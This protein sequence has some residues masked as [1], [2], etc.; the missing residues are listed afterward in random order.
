[1]ETATY[2][3]CTRWPDPPHRHAPTCRVFHEYLHATMHRSIRSLEEDAARPHLRQQLVGASAM[4]GQLLGDDLHGLPTSEG[5]L[6][7]PEPHLLNEG[8]APAQ[9]RAPTPTEG[10][11]TPQV[12]EATDLEPC[13]RPA[14]PPGATPAGMGAE[15]VVP[16][17]THL[18]VLGATARASTDMESFYSPR[19]SD[20]AEEVPTGHCRE[21]ASPADDTQPEHL[22]ALAVTPGPVGDAPVATTVPSDD[23]SDGP[24]A[25]APA[26]RLKACPL[27]PP[28][29]VQPPGDGA[30]LSN[31]QDAGDE[32]D[33]EYWDR[34]S[35]DPSNTFGTIDL[36]EFLY[37]SPPIGSNMRAGS[38]RTTVVVDHTTPAQPQ[39]PSH[40][41][42]TQGPQPATQDRGQAARQPIQW[43]KLLSDDRRLGQRRGAPQATDAPGSHWPPTMD[44]D[45]H[46]PSSRPTHGADPSDYTQNTQGGDRHTDAWH[47]PRRRYDT[48]EYYQQ[49]WQHQTQ[50]SG[51]DEREWAWHSESEEGSSVWPQEPRFPLHDPDPQK[52]YTGVVYL[53]AKRR[54]YQ[55]L[56]VATLR[57]T[58]GGRQGPLLGITN[59]A[60]DAPKRTDTL[61]WAHRVACRLLLQ[62]LGLRPKTYKLYPTAFRLDVPE[63]IRPLSGKATHAVATLAIME[64]D[65]D[66]LDC[67]ACTG[68]WEYF[69][70]LQ[71]VPWPIFRGTKD[72]REW[73]SH[74]TWS[75][76]QYNYRKQ[77]GL[78]AHYWWWLDMLAS[79]VVSH[80]APATRWEGE[81]ADVP[82]PPPD[83]GRLVGIRPGASGDELRRAMDAHSLEL[84]ETDIA[85][86]H[87]WYLPSAARILRWDSEAVWSRR[88]AEP[89]YPGMETDWRYKT[90][91]AVEPK[92]VRVWP[93]HV[94]TST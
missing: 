16:R 18:P 10:G 76:F 56:Y 62:K 47:G 33:T 31:Q 69:Q 63:G 53:L 59:A 35:A 80:P 15:L 1:M 42:D 72:A 38:P 52:L 89:Y 23:S 88:Q 78:P 24:A 75:P 61:P 7:T 67:Q 60:V 43:E 58:Q 66:V 27:P 41:A 86:L 74:I 21:Q 90:I 54:P 71:N 70:H 44:G 39:A 12:P 92:W 4:L 85:H 34:F 14:D 57:Y 11:H 68:E 49:Q 37:Q 51:M 8:A 2:C 19:P 91:L 36:P 25:V 83:V 28:G 73:S 20:S 32:E 87:Q 3:T 30:P 55:H 93:P 29:S 26:P 5:W 77:D 79:W 17:P 9:D 64:K 94:G 50:F 65:L 46:G 40:E 84:T 81:L 48:Q 45:G 6:W 22:Q 13:R 82:A